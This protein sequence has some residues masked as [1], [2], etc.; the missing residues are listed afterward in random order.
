MI[1]Q[2]MK[3][4]YD[5]IH[6]QKWQATIEF[7]KNDVANHIVKYIMSYKLRLW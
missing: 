5:P 2:I 7:L 3:G 1:W 4:P 6:D